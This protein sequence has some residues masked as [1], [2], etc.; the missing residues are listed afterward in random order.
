VWYWHSNPNGGQVKTSEAVTGMENSP[1]SPCI[2]RFLSENPYIRRFDFDSPLP[3]ELR[4]PPF[5]PRI[6]RQLMICRSRLDSLF[7]ITIRLANKQYFGYNTETSKSVLC[8]SGNFEVRSTVDQMSGTTMKKESVPLS[9]VER[10]AQTFCEYGDFILAVIHYQSGNHVQADD[11]LQDFF[12]S[13][14]SKPVPSGIQNV[15]GYLYRA[16]TNDIADAARRVKKYRALMHKYAESLDYSVNKSTPE[17]ALIETEEM[18]KTFKLIEGYLPRS[19]AQAITFRYRDNCDIKEVSKKMR[20]NHRSV[21]KYI[22][23]GL[24]KIRRF[25]PIKQGN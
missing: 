25:W 17:N 23:A 18:N 21:S 7:S 2:T 14:V 10:A 6:S 8:F 9:N 19:Q 3:E 15:K 16:I 13:L 24:R 11:L 20:I 12:L 22:S 5:P 1:P 4:S